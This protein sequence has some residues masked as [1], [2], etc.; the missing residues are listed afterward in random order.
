[1]QLRARRKHIGERVQEVTGVLDRAFCER[2]VLKGENVLAVEI[3]NL[4]DARPAAVPQLSET[5]VSGGSCAMQED[6]RGPFA[7]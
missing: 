7:V 4:G 6:E 5:P 2:P 1:M 3:R